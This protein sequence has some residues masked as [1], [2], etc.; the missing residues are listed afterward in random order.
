MNADSNRRGKERG[1]TAAGGTDFGHHGARAC[2]KVCEP[3]L[4]GIKGER[5][6]RRWWSLS[7]LCSANEKDTELALFKKEEKKEKVAPAVRVAGGGAVGEEWR[8]RSSCN[9][10]EKEPC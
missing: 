8:R 3:E 1:G 2:A 9:G 10:E 4:R 6:A 5:E 7:L